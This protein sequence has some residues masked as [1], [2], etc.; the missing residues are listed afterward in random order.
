[1]HYYLNAAKLFNY[2]GEKYSDTCFS[3]QVM[4]VYHHLVRHSFVRISLIR[5]ARHLLLWLVL[6]R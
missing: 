3:K 5:Y 1:M 2:A 4:P 6:K